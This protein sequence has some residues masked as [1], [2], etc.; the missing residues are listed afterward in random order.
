MAGVDETSEKGDVE[1]GEKTT[2]VWTSGNIPV[3]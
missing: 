2:A 1:K 3:S